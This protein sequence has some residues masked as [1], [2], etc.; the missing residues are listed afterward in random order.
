MICLVTYKH[1]YGLFK[2]PKDLQVGMRCSV[3]QDCDG[4]QNDE[5]G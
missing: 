1:A 5:R 4:M 2:D 3:K